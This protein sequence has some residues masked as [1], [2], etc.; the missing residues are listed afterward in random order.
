MNSTA[1]MPVSEKIRPS[2]LNSVLLFDTIISL[3]ERIA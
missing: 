1:G 3:G 2:V